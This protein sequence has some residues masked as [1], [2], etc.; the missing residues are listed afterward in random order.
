MIIIVSTL[1]FEVSILNII[2]STLQF[3][4]STLNIL[5]SVWHL[6]QKVWVREA[7]RLP[8][9]GKFN[10]NHIALYCLHYT[11]HAVGAV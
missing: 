6:S 2:V 5:V 9:K 1:H 3:E 7:V 11:L 10:V 8:R 4:L